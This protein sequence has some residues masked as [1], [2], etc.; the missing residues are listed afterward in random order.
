MARIESEIA[1]IVLSPPM[2][3]AIACIITACAALVWSMR[4]KPWVRSVS[5]RSL[6][7]RVTAMRCGWTVVTA[8]GSLCSIHSASCCSA[9]SAVGRSKCLHLKAAYAA[10]GVEAVIRGWDQRSVNEKAFHEW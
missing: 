5:I 8:A 1:M 10:L 2:L 9:K 4:R 6:T 7:I 3:A